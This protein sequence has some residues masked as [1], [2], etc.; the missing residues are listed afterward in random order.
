M[1]IESLTALRPVKKKK[2]QKVTKKNK[3]NIGPEAARNLVNLYY[4]K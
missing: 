2:P 3:S 4:K 1:D